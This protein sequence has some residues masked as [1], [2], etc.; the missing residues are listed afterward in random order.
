MA[1]RLRRFA[2]GLGA[3]RPPARNAIQSC[4]QLLYHS[5]GDRSICRGVTNHSRFS[6]E[7]APP[8]PQAG[9][10]HPP[11]IF[12]PLFPCPA[13]IVVSAKRG[14]TVVG[15]DASKTKYAA[16]AACGFAN[17]M[18]P[19]RQCITLH[20]NATFLA[21]APNATSPARHNAAQCDTSHAP[22][23]RD[24]PSFH[25]PR[26]ARH[27]TQKRSTNRIEP[28]A[29]APKPPP[30]SRHRGSSSYQPQTKTTERTQYALRARLCLPFIH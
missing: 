17:A 7:S 27:L 6:I 20:Q 24:T 15:P 18:R 5:F 19:D 25:K 23:P 26:A 4:F 10:A 14:G 2:L 1:A 8:Q 30:R 21:P 12:R 13:A 29:P 16:S 11:P 22:S 3:L 28:T 9:P